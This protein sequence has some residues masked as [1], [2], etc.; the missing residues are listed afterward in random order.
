MCLCSYIT[1]NGKFM[2]KSELEKKIKLAQDS[3]YNNSSIMEDDEYDALIYELTCLDPN[4]QLIIKI[5]AEPTDEWKKVKHLIDLGSLNKV[6]LPS[7]MTDW[8][9][10]TLQNRDVVVVEKLDGLSIGCQYQNGK[11]VVAALRGNGYEGENIL[12]NVLKMKGCVKSVPNF[13]GTIRGEIVLTKSDHEQFFKDYSNPRNAASGLCRRLD[14][15]GCEHLTLMFYQAAGE[16]EFTTDF[17]MLKFLTTNKF[18]T[19]KYTLCTSAIKVNEIWQEYQDKTRQELE[20]EIDGLVVSCND[21]AFQQSL[22][23]TNLRPK[24]K[25]GFKFANQ[26][27]KTTVKEIKWACGNSGRITPVCW[28]EPVLLLGSTVEKASVYNIDYIKKLGLD[29]GAEV[30]ICKAGEIIPRIEQVVKGTGTTAKVPTNCPSCG[31]EAQ[32]DGKHLICPNETSCPARTLGRIQNWVNE[33]NL[34]EWGESL[35]SKLVE[36]GKATTVADLYTLTVDN[37]ASIDRMGKKSAQKC[38]DILH[39]H[40]EVSLEVFLGGLSIPMIGQSTIK[41]IMSTGCDTLEKISKMD[42][43]ALEKVPGVGPTK[44]ES[45]EKGLKNNQQLI[46]ELL[47]NGIKIKE[48]I[49][50]NLSDKSFVFTGKMLNKRAELEEMVVSAGGTTKSSVTKGVTYLV[51]A[52]PE[53]MSSKAVSARKLGTQLISEED[54]LEM[55]K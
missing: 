31:T 41:A 24:G 13:T 45:L 6:N 9:G 49:M 40:N 3:Y 47:A 38:Y 48:K 42:T 12:S 33:L 35:L 26:F 4:N 34:L 2:L 21:F 32:M 7:E 23:T 5:G 44:A 16:E 52:D 25:M 10:K 46:S 54:F 19:P 51:I 43:V 11:L 37:L 20:Y 50:G 22:G 17:E 14:G 18:I 27:V 1:E 39:S 55:V 28:V 15:D 29:V 36:T 53:S 8:I 30:L